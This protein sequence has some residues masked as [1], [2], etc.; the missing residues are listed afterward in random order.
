[1]FSALDEK[2]Q[3]IIVDAM[4]EKIFQYINNYFIKNTD[5][6]ICY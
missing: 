5:L 6:E 3:K 2:E 1:M 4:E